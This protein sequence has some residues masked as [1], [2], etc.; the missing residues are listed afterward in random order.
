MGIRTVADV[1]RD[2]FPAGTSVVGG[3]EG[4]RRPVVQAVTPRLRGGF[5]DLRQGTLAIVSVETLHLLPAQ[6]T[7]AQTIRGLARMGV[8]ALA[9]F[10]RIE[11]WQQPATCWMA[12]KHGC[13]LLQL[14]LTKVQSSL[15]LTQAINSYL[16]SSG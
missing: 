10:G 6:P 14:P 4:L 5:A 2:T 11:P 13:A 1:V 8:V 15:E 7:V 16:D 3:K 9:L 12:D